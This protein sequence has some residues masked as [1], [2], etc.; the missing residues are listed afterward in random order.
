MKSLL[1]GIVLFPINALLFLWAI[2]RVLFLWSLVVIL[3]GLL[4][5]LADT[6]EWLWRVYGIIVV[7]SLIYIFRFQNEETQRTD[8][9][10]RS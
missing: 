1:W 6:F 3:G 9:V 8:D 5:S 4:I 7:A 10:G 2:R